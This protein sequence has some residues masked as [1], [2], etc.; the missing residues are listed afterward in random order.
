MDDLNLQYVQYLGIT[1]AAVL[2]GCRRLPFTL[3]SLF[4]VVGTRPWLTLDDLDQ[5]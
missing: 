2:H 1:E 5:C 4:P 3:H